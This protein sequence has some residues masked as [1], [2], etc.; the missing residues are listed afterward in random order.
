MFLILFYLCAGYLKAQLLEDLL[1]IVEPTLDKDKKHEREVLF[2][3]I[4][5]I[6]C[7]YETSELVSGARVII[8]G[9]P[10]ETYSNADGM[11]EITEVPDGEYELVFIHK[12]YMK[13]KMRPVTVL[14]NTDLAMRVTL[15]RIERSIGDVEDETEVFTIK[16]E[17]ERFNNMIGRKDVNKRLVKLVKYTSNNKNELYSPEIFAI[18]DELR[19]V[20]D[21]IAVFLK[22]HPQANV[23][24]AAYTQNPSTHADVA[25]RNTQQRATLMQSY[26]VQKHKIN[27]ERIHAEGLGKHNPHKDTKDAIIHTKHHLI[28]KLR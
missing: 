14:G 18:S 11:Y 10:F 28:I 9:T 3:N 7:D 23:V 17:L 22:K 12:D 8:T 15:D 25:R 27:K 2:G 13:K 24:L 26:I 5:G 19:V 4:R 6:I 16:D 1:K 20:L 21:S